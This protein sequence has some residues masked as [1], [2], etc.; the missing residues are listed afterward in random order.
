MTALDRMNVSSG[1]KCR[2][3]CLDA[4]NSRI[5]GFVADVPA[6]RIEVVTAG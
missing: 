2:G 3:G 4:A 5:N 6:H 1:L